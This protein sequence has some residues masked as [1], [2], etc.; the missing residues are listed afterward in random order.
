ML[1]NTSVASLL[2]E[3]KQQ[4]GAAHSFRWTDGEAISTDTTD[5]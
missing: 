3:E 5:T 4:V 2:A 1:I